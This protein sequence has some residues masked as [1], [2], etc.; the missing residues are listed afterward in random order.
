MPNA[1]DR[2]CRD[3][4]HALAGL[5]SP[6]C[7]ECGRG[8]DPDDP[9][10]TVDSPKPWRRTIAALV[11]P[12][13]VFNLL[14]AT[15]VVIANGIG[16]DPLL[17]FLIAVGLSPALLLPL[18]A[19]PFPSLPLK[20]RWR[21]LAVLA[22]LAVVTTVLTDWPVRVLFEMHRSAFVA[23]AARIRAV[24][25]PASLGQGVGDR[26]SGPIRVGTFSVLR[27]RET[28]DGNLGFQLSGDG[29]GGVYVV[30]AVPGSRF[31][32]WNTNWETNL[33]GGWWIVY[34][35]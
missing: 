14:V 12:L 1:L 8:F 30:E 11:R 20:R 16:L 34:E 13:V 23:E 27:V 5:R 17:G 15:A 4:G 33:G 21:V 35:D 19:V 26:R 31:I 6:I 29:G 9:R 2:F 3:C 28:P 24:P 32:W 10:T 25:T 18:A 22:P 7:P